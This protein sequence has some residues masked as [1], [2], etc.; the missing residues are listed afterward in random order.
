MGL[1]PKRIPA[2]SILPDSWPFHPPAGMRLVD[3]RKLEDLAEHAAAWTELFSRSAGL[4]PMLSYP[5]MSAYF[6][7]KVAYPESWLCLFAYEGKQLVGVFPLIA[8]YAYR[9]IKY[10]P[11]LFKLPYDILH[12][13]SVDA[14]TI[15]GREDVLGVFFDYLFH[16]PSG[17]PFFSFK[18]VPAHS[19]SM[20]YF[21][22][23]KREICVI[24]KPAGFQSILPLP[25]SA[26]KYR[27][28]LSTKFRQYLK[29][30]TR[31]LDELDKVNFIIDDNNSP[32]RE[33]IAR[34]LEVEHKN[35]KGQQSSS[36]K[37]DQTNADLFADAAELFTAYDMM[38]FNFLEADGKTI[39]AQYAIRAN[40][41]L[42]VH[43]IGYDED[44][45]DFSPG[46]LLFNKVI[47]HACESGKFDELNFM[48]DSP[49][50]SKWNIEKRPLYN[51][52][53]FP[54]KTVISSLLTMILQ[55]G[56]LR[57]LNEYHPRSQKAKTD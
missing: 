30:N 15:Q 26:E 47:E 38:H 10:S 4:T 21:T 41:S 9:F 2:L 37:A 54:G 44:Y 5:W 39:A 25:D 22:K 1:L 29:R 6:K 56:A 17:Y 27:A 35:W 14:L 24:E 18:Y 19:P 49:W 46:N 23:Q 16:I 34:F 12:T 48:S 57:K 52:L 45:I 31:K 55:S 51:L 32:P 36:L 20:I 13:K 3:V 43:K 7:N 53:V 28:G 11:L 50:H 40:R 33:S 8:G 42:Y